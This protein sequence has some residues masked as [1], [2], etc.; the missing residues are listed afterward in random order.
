MDELAPLEE[1]RQ[2]VAVWLAWPGFARQDAALVPYFPSYRV[3]FVL[4]RDFWR[5]K[6]RTVGSDML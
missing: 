4:L 1:E 3:I 2:A 6:L 5:E